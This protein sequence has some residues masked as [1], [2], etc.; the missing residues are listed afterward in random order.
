[1]SYS[2]NANRYAMLLF[3]V[4]TVLL[5]T[6]NGRVHGQSSHQWNERPLKPTGLPVTQGQSPVLIIDDL[7][8]FPV[9]G[10]AVDRVLS[11]FAGL[12]RLASFTLDSQASETALPG[13]RLI[14][15]VSSKDE[16]AIL[17]RFDAAYSPDGRWLLSAN[18]RAGNRLS[19][20]DVQGLPFPFGDEAASSLEVDPKSGAYRLVV[21]D[22]GRLHAPRIAHEFMRQL[23]E[24]MSLDKVRIAMESDE[25]ALANDV[26]F[27][28]YRKEL[29]LVLEYF[30]EYSWLVE[31]T[32]G[33]LELLKKSAI[34]KTPTQASS[35]LA[36][37]PSANTG[38]RR[39]GSASSRGEHKSDKSQSNTSRLSG[40]ATTRLAQV[41]VD[42]NKHLKSLGDVSQAEAVLAQP[43][44]AKPVLVSSHSVREAPG[45]AITF[46][47][48]IDG[49][50]SG[51]EFEYR[52]RS[53]RGEW[54]VQRNYS[55]NSSW[56]W[57]TSGWPVDIYNVTAFARRIG[58]TAAYEVAATP[59]ATTLTT[60]SPATGVSLTSD[61]GT[62]TVVGEVVRFTAAGRGGKG[63]YEYQYRLRSNQLAWHVVRDYTTDSS[64]LWNTSVYSPNE[65][66]FEVKVRSTGSPSE[67]EA[68]AI[69]PKQLLV[70]RQ[71]ATGATLTANQSTRISPGTIVTFSGTAQGTAP[72]YEYE[73]HIR[74][75]HTEWRTVSNYSTNSQWRWDTTGLSVDV[76]YV[77]P[78]VRQVGSRA[79]YEAAAAPMSI[80][81]TTVAP[82]T[83]VTVVSDHS[84]TARSGSVVVIQSQG[85]G[86]SG[87]YEYRIRVKLDDRWQLMKD[88]DANS[89]WS[90]NTAGLAPGVYN[91]EIGAR[92]L[93]SPSAPEAYKII[94]ITLREN[95]EQLWDRVLTPYLQQDL[96]SNTNIE[97]ATHTLQVPMER[98]FAV[99]D[100]RWRNEFADQFRRFMEAKPTIDSQ[101]WRLEYYYLASRFVTLCA[102]TG[103]P[104]LIPDGMVK[105]LYDEVERLWLYEPAWLW[106]SPPFPGGMRERVIWKRDTLV[107]KHKY[108][109]GI[110]EHDIFVITIAAELKKYERLTGIV[111]I[112]TVVLDDVLQIARTMFEGMIVLQPDGGW[113]F[114][115]GVWSDHPEW[116]YAGHP[117][118][119][120]NL[121]PLPVPDIAEDA[122]HAIRWPLWLKSM[123]EAYPTGSEGRAYYLNLLSGLEIQF[124]EH[125]LVE[126]TSDFDGYRSN[127]FMDGR[128]GVYRYNY[129]TAGQGRGYGPY[130]VSAAMFYGWWSFLNTDRTREFYEYMGRRFP[131]TDS[132]IDAYVGPNTTRVRNPL[133]TMPATFSNGLKEVLTLLA[134]F[135][136]WT[137]SQ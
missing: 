120:P 46:T 124:M 103:H 132:M 22:S 113:L 3:A 14:D 101:L 12:A 13:T 130:S 68:Y 18:R 87:I 102:Q 59:F 79:A 56:T 17:H 36:S 11:K 6:V 72:A 41:N 16:A 128:N 133:E 75:S 89:A 42:Q 49:S 55:S 81:L 43:P 35:R 98:A 47:A 1:M 38:L 91:V 93:G 108:Y 94:T 116:L 107:T 69:S 9:S 4:V 125:V 34:V 54:K 62:T 131:L 23:V 78:F 29:T 15:G 26:E 96:W 71:P 25:P 105:L 52:M 51:V 135:N 50:S 84:R 32:A 27:D 92:S 90:W 30:E 74:S 82:A 61:G 8:E 64:W 100:S 66:Y 57:S 37:Q 70:S 7:V 106:D 123:A 5:L 111:D 99:Q 19:V 80:T 112:R 39:A 88:F 134:S 53:S 109:R 126:P 28:A 110:T 44:L 118:V 121:Q 73:Y 10:R 31:N 45:T 67:W 122:S 58:S 86:G 127:N 95:V 2:C 117:E 20:G 65:Y 24:S 60:V 83:G 33:E 129:Y 114:Q 63:P 48:V 76:Y 97:D 115:P 137:P 85:Q 119:L 104:E 40:P 136:L 77:T 21:D